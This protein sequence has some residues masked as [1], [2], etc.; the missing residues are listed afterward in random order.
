MQWLA[1]HAQTAWYSGLMLIAWIVWRMRGDVRKTT[2]LWIGSR[3]V[4][5][6]VL[7]FA[8]AAAQL[9]PTLEY[10]SLS[11]RAGELDRQFALTYSFWPWRILG[12]IFPGLFGNPAIGDF[13]GYGNYWEDAIYIG[14]MPLIFS[15]GSI[16]KGLR[17][18][19]TT[20]AL[21]RFLLLVSGLSLMLALGKNTPVF[22]FLFDHVPSFNL[23]QAPARWNLLLVFSLA[24]LAGRGADRWKTPEGRG[25]YWTRLLTAGAGIIAIASYLGLQWIPNLQASFFRSFVVSGIILTICGLLTLFFPKQHRRLAILMVGGFILTDLLL[26]GQGL[27]PTISPEVFEGNV[28]GAKGIVG[29]IYMPGDLEQR[30]KFEQ[31]HRFDTFDPGVDWAEIREIGLPNTN[32]LDNV[33]S[34]NNFDPLVTSRFATFL[35]A[36]EGM[37]TTDQDRFLAWMDVAYRIDADPEDPQG[38]VFKPLVPEGRLH[39]LS[40]AIAASSA[41]EALDLVTAAEFDYSSQV[42]LE[43]P[44]STLFETHGSG[45][46]LAYHD[47]GP[48]AISI[49]VDMVDDGWLVLADAWYPGWEATI[50]GEQTEIFRANY[51]FKGIALPAGIH[52]VL[53]RYHPVSF[54]TGGAISLVSI[55]AFVVLGTVCSR[56]D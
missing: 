27:N 18:W 15:L 13:W 9:L 49:S 37:P 10:L 11:P 25:L 20:F 32:M 38:V 53:I 21:E 1:G 52:D 36:L 30:L 26:A 56:R 33:A 34:L 55:F 39:V 47:E 48:D 7:A 19:E 45:A 43:G 50:D 6:G 2:V 42:V 8:I 54:I 51:L 28:L 14:L 29:R 12:L 31:T 22:P 17:R 46:I 40:E 44:A 35:T 24:I 4:I 23:F 5:I 41:E 16:W 3:L